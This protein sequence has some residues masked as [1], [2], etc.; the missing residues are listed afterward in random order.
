MPWPNPRFGP[1][2]RPMSR[3]SGAGNRPGSRLTAPRHTSACSRAGIF[4][5]SRVTGSAVTRNVACGTGAVKRMSL[6]IAAG[7]CPGSASSAWSWPGLSSR[8]TTP[9]PIRLAVVSWPATMS[10]NRLDSSSWVV[11]ASHSVAAAR[12]LTR[13]PAGLRRLASR[14]RCR[15]MPRRPPPA[16]H[17]PIRSA[18]QRTRRAG[19]AGRLR[20]CRAARRSPRTAADILHGYA[21]TRLLSVRGFPSPFVLGGGVHG[22]RLTMWGGQS[23]CW[24]RDAR[25]CPRQ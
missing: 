24:V 22:S 11:S 25:P 6:S 5:P 13:S 16:G 21:R 20:G 8:A 3:T 4:T 17:R 19:A 10:W 7:S 14:P 1:S 23:P 12:T 15:P 9:L 2:P 18:A